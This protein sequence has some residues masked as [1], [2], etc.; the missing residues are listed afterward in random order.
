MN[1]ISDARVGRPCFPLVGGCLAILALLMSL[2]SVSIAAAQNAGIDVVLLMDSSGSMAKNDPRKLR[3]PAA[4]LFMSLLGQN[5]RIGLVSFS[6]N[7]YPVLHLTAA[8]ADGSARIL[9][10]ADKVSSK[11]VYTNLYAA[12]A[13]GVSMLTKEGQAGQEKMLI[14]MSD[15]KM[16]VGD[17]DEDGRLTQRLQEELL[18]T[19]EEKGIKVY[20]IAFTEAS[21][22]DLL[23]DIARR[24]GA[25]FKLAKSDPDLH[26]VFSDI[27]ESAKS[28]DMLPIDGGEFSVDPSIEEVTIVASKEREDVRIF[29]QTPQGQEISSEDA[30]GDLKWFVSENFDMIT[31][32]KPES[33]TWK[34]LFTGGKNRA[35][36]VTNMTLNHNPQQPSLRAGEDMVL[37]TWLEQ[38]GKLLDKEALLTNTRFRM[39]IVGPDGRST[40]FDLFDDGQSGDRKAADGVYS[41]TLM[42]DIPGSYRA[43]LIAE[44]ETF[45]RQKTVHFEVQAPPPGSQPAQP[46]P[47][48]AEQAPAAEAQTAPDADVQPSAGPEP[49]ATTPEEPAAAPPAPEPAKKGINL[50]VAIGIFFG[51]NLL[52]VGIGFSVWWFMKKRK[53][54]AA[55]PAEP[56]DEQED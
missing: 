48:P 14:L 16:D 19:I 45:K 27:F 54:K 21:D 22:I 4:K 55:A 44:S 38:D 9:A 28:P 46:A 17:S 35:Y 30:G 2:A 31:L 37:E 8:T 53:Q 5:D 10:S 23:R 25:L 3:V 18:K 42:Y 51:V 20:T 32:R 6:D 26:E 24:S 34:L 13:S 12:L 1:R 56:A 33:G 40:G 43:D 49:P 39:N 47:A 52:L 50:G 36:I 11:G 15:G 29:L 7:G 41:N